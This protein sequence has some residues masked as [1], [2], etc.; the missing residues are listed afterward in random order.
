MTIRDAIKTFLVA[1]ATAAGS[2][3]HAGEVPQTTEPPY[4]VF[5]EVGKPPTHTHEGASNA[6][7]QTFQVTVWATKEP[8]AAAIGTQIRRAMDGYRGLMGDVPVKGAFL[9]TEREGRDDV[10]NRHYISQD[11]DVFYN[12]SDV[13]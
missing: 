8:D 1:Q 11:Y 3:V 5:F 7:Q 12:D 2:K 13:S 4:I 9:E 6:V 10:T